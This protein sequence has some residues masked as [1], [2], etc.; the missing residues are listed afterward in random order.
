MKVFKKLNVSTIKRKL[1]KIKKWFTV[2]RVLVFATI[3]NTI[4]LCPLI[5]D[6]FVRPNLELTVLSNFNSQKIIMPYYGLTNTGNK[7]AENIEIVFE[8]H[9]KYKIVS[10][11][12]LDL[13]TEIMSYIKDEKVNKFPLA[14]F[15]LSIKKIVPKEQVV[16]IVYGDAKV[17]G[18]TLE[19][20]DK[21][22]RQPKLISCRHD[23][24]LCKLK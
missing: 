1:R 10:A 16:F 23:H 7:T 4:L 18:T 14:F 21:S 9:N 20:M 8:M 11:G 17:W 2:Q 19:D 3:M 15:K 12:Y 24:G 6:Y 13:K 22:V 5:I